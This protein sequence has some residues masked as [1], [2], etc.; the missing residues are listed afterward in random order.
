MRFTPQSDEALE[1]EAAERTAKFLWAAGEY[2][3]E[4]LEG[5]DTVSGAGNDMMKINVTVYHND[6]RTQNIYDYLLESM[7]FKLKHSAYACG[8]GEKYEDADLHGE[9]YIG[10]SGKLILGI[11]PPQNGYGTKNVIKDY[12]VSDGMKYQQNIK[13]DKITK[14]EL[15]DEI[16]F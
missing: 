4:V 12:V 10:K 3:F 8:L 7:P 16:P 6:G 9:D 2:D 15:D 14:T 13:A 1:A 5:F 11:Q